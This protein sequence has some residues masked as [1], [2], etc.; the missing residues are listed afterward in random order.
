MKSISVTTVLG[1]FTD[2]DKINPAVLEAAQIRGTAVHAAAS[3]YAKG[4]FVSPL[5]DGYQGYYLSF[6]NWFDSYVD[7]V[8]FVEQR[9]FDK[10]F[11]FNGKPDL[12]VILK[13]GRAVI[14]DY[15]TAVAE[16]QTWKSQLAA[17]RHLALKEFHYDFEVMSLRL[18][19]DGRPAKA[20]TYNYSESDFA[21]FLAALTA[22][23]YFIK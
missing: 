2:F 3:A 20:V 9:F 22:Y 10:T 13:D 4:L 12:G 7:T 11:F 17:Y 5:Q 21:A 1:R 18:K 19:E 6:K 15:K 14:T 23:R 8:I 16:G